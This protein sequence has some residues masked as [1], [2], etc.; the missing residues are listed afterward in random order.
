MYSG[1]FDDLTSGDSKT[2]KDLTG[3]LM[4]KIGFY[5]KKQGFSNDYR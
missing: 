2:R 1:V 3:F 4:K 5:W